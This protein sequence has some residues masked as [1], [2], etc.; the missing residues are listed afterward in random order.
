M[1]QGQVTHCVKR[2]EACAVSAGVLEFLNDSFIEIG[3][4]ERG[5]VRQFV[6]LEVVPQRFHR[7]ELWSPRGK[8]FD[9]QAREALHQIP[10]TRSFVD[11]RLIPNDDQRP[12]NL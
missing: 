1:P 9:G 12:P 10:K 7:I 6:V 5:E 2:I 4:I 3:D 11:V 8:G